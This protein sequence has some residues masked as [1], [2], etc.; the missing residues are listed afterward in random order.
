MGGYEEVTRDHL[1]E[2]GA[3]IKSSV[4]LTV[5]T[6][7]KD[8]TW[9][10]SGFLIELSERSAKILTNH[11]CFAQT[12]YPHDPTEETMEDACSVAIIFFSLS[13]SDQ[14][15]AVCHDIEVEEPALDLMILSIEPRHDEFPEGIAP[16]EVSSEAL[17]GDPAYM[18]HHPVG[19]GDMKNYGELFLP[20]PMISKDECAITNDNQ[21]L[22]YAF[23]N[24]DRVKTSLQHSCGSMPGSSGAAIISQRTHEVVGMHWG[25]IQVKRDGSE[26]GTLT[27]GGGSVKPSCL[28][29]F[30]DGLGRCLDETLMVTAPRP[31]GG[32]EVSSGCHGGLAGESSKQGM[33]M[34]MAWLMMP[35]MTALRRRKG[36]RKYENHV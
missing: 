35:T 29:G 14:A 5:P 24:A 9:F 33:F 34:V 21:S 26:T 4:L 32:W 12:S 23:P 1:D 15:S 20:P 10:C 31:V 2:Y 22:H 17:F 6:D 7:Q 25:K 3:G 27:I 30:K 19:H 16:I 36:G 18:V 13:I 8:L 11:H 28:L